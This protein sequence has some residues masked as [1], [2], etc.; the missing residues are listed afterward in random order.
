MLSKE[1]VKAAAAGHWHEIF[2][3]L[4]PALHKALEHP[5]RHVPCPVHGGTDGFR[6]FPRY[7]EKGDCICNSCGAFKDGLATLQWVNKW[8]FKTAVERVGAFLGIVETGTPVE[9]DSRDYDGTLLH[10]GDVR[11]GNRRGVGLK[12]QVKNRI[13]TLWGVDLVRAC[14]AAGVAPG[15][16]IRASRIGQSRLR[17]GHTLNSWVVSKLKTEKEKLA[18]EQAREAELQRNRESIKEIWNASIPITR[19]CPAGLYLAR[20][21][22]DITAIPSTGLRFCESECAMIACVK[23]AAGKCV[24]LHKTFLTTDGRKADVVYPKL[25]M[26]LAADTMSGSAIRLALHKDVLAVAEG[27]ETALSVTYATGIPC[28]SCVSANGLEAVQIPEDVKTV[29]IFA[30]KD[31]SC[32][33][34][35]AAKKLADRLSKEGFLALVMAIEDPI[36]ECAK[37]IDWNDIL[38]RRGK[39]AFPVGGSGLA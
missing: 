7:R 23:N 15:N 39:T 1:K 26:K 31:R 22:I 10:F 12:L 34:A 24:T 27:I 3:A 25:L 35:K 4:A 14:K 30:D 29:L 17:N 2:H 8:D 13:L 20:R 32:T 5:G 9:V 28:W 6:L 37:G 18:E 19:D 33:G 38:Q 36:P 21:G 11:V 16:F